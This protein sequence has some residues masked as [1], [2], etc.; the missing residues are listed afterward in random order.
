M[1]KRTLY[2]GNPA[3]LS[4][5]NSQMVFRLLNT[6][7]FHIISE[8]ECPPRTFPIE[9]I[10]YIVLDHKQITITQGLIDALLD[11]MCALVTC[12]SNHLP[13]GLMLPLSGNILQQERFEAQINSSLPL[14]KQLWQQTVKCKI[15][16][17]AAV[18]ESHVGKQMANMRAWVQDVRSNDSTNLEGRAAAFYWKELFYDQAKFVRDQD[19]QWPNN[20]LNYGYAILRAIIARALVCKGLLPTFGIHHHNRYNAYC[21]A[22]DIMEPYRPVVDRMV[23]DII[24]KYPEETNLSTD[25]KRELL[26]LPVKEVV[27]EGHRSPLMIAADTTANSLLRCFMGFSRQISY[28]TL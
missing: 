6:T 5:Q 8:K 10:G 12:S 11:N 21:L 3:Y 7:D 28:P 25:I 14:R 23:L 26:S 27:I 19:G 9:D 17:Q 1:L 16:N 22:D 4:L 24:K 20:F 15:A 2:F 13:T 18:L